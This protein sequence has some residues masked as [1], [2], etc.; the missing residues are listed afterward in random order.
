MRFNGANDDGDDDIEDDDIN[1]EQ[2]E[3]SRVLYSRHDIPASQRNSH[4]EILIVLRSRAR[5]Y[6]SLAWTAASAHLRTN[7]PG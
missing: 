6:V 7:A 4:S 2:N 5:G 1:E 3:T